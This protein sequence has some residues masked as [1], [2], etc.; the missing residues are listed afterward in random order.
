MPSVTDIA[1][2]AL[3]E[4]GADLIMDIGEN[5]RNAKICQARYPDVRDAVLRSHPWNCATSRF[6]VPAEGEVPAYGFG[7]QYPLPTSPYC[8]RIIELEDPGL[9]WKLEGR[10][11]LTDAVGPLRGLYIGR[12]GEDLMDALLVQSLAM[13]LGAAVAYRL[14]TSQTQV[15]RM[16]K[17]YRDMISEARSID[18][19]EGVPDEMPDSTI[20]NARY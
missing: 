7:A 20:L 14:T 1:N 10:R 3:S 11:I 12:I 19:Q 4:L 15:D 13:R 9:R 16:T 18:A 8:L 17:L 2:I 5:T 6:S